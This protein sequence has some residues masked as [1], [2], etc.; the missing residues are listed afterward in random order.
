M[1]VDVDIDLFRNP[2]L[3][4]FGEVFVNHLTGGDTNQFKVLKIL[5]SQRVVPIGGFQVLVG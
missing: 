4:L 3:H 2:L 1:N 5:E